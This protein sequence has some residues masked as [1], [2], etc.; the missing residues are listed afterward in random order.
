[1]RSTAL[2]IVLVALV[3]TGEAL[4]CYAQDGTILQCTYGNEDLCMNYD[5][6]TVKCKRCGMKDDCDDADM[7]REFP[8]FFCCRGDLCNK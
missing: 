3:S 8:T 7:K 1:M 2:L 5:D 6:G 4:R